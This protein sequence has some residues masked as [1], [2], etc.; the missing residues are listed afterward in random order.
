MG[1]SSKPNLT[2]VQGG[3]PRNAPRI[4]WERPNLRL[5][6]GGAPNVIND[7]QFDAAVYSPLEVTEM[8]EVRSEGTSRKKKQSPK[9]PKH[10][11]DYR[12]WDDDYYD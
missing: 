4:P 2:V 1:K 11:R 3:L 12:D 5:I 6:M 9:Q 8:P 10:N 7:E